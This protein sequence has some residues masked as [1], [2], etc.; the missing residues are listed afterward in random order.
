MQPSGYS[1]VAHALEQ[2][3]RDLRQSSNNSVVLLTSSV[4]GCGGDPCRA[5]SRLIREGAVD[6]LY[7]IG[8]GVDRDQVRRLDCV[9]TYYQ[10]NTPGE[11]KSALRDVIRSSTRSGPGTLSILRADGSRELVAGGFL[12]EKIKLAS[13]SYD[14]LIK[15]EGKTY[16]WE[17]LRVEGNLET[18]AGRR[19]PRTR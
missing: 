10:A 1:P 16:R 13:G 8:L 12:G 19:P 2:V 5:A 18:T 4:D 14:V 7:V 6:R 17:R 11:L 15:T 9:G 3:G